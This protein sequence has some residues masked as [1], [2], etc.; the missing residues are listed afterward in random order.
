[1]G[2]RRLL[3]QVKRQESQLRKL[4]NSAAQLHRTSLYARRGVHKLSS[5]ARTSTMGGSSYFASLARRVREAEASSDAAYL[6]ELYHRNDPETIMLWLMWIGL[7]KVSCLRHCTEVKRQ[8]S[9]LRKLSNSAAQLHRTS[10]YARRGV[11]K[12]SSTAEQVPWEDQ[13]ASLARGVREAE[14]SSDAA[15]LKELYHRN[16]PETIMLWLRWI[17]LTKVSC[18]RHCIESGDH[19]CTYTHGDCRGRAFQRAIRRTV[20]SLGMA[21]LLISGFGALIEDKGI[22]LGLH[23]EVQP[24]MEL[25]TKVS[26]V[27][28]VDEAKAELEE[29]VHYLRDPKGIKYVDFI[30]AILMSWCQASKR[31]SASWSP[32]T[33]K[34]MLARAVAGEAGVLFFS[35]SGSEFEEVFVGVGARRVRDLFAA[36]KEVPCIIFIDE[37]DA[38]GGSRN[39]KDQQYM[40]MTLNSCLLNWMASNKMKGLL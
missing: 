37:I 28:G 2:L 26:D 8:E 22:G 20:R 38:I 25:N 15:Y 29:I 7:T 9:Q 35:C 30:A 17:G 39:L 32:A 4:S 40:K 6:K 11:H 33:G 16:D 12:L 14:A 34:T 31:R 3:S 36:E 21:F 24:S 18:L 5:T 27:K 10:L 1:M 13:L 23:E 19:K